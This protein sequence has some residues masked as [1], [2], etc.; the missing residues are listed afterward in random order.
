MTTL[1]FLSGMGCGALVAVVFMLFI[2]HASLRSTKAMNARYEAYQL[3][4][5]AEMRRRNELLE[6]QNFLISEK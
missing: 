2:L 3:K 1:I 5:L 4:T 6:R